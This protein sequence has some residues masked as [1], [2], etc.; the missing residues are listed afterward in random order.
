MIS[1]AFLVTVVILSLSGV[2]T[3]GPLFLA[4]ILRATKSGTMAGV[5]CAVGHTIVELPLVVGL[6]IG[7]SAFFSQPL[8]KAIAIV[9]GLVLVGLAVL[10][11]NQARS[12]IEMN[13]SNFSEKLSR[14]PTIL[15]GIA[16]TGLNPFF[17][18]W[19][20][21]VGTYLISQAYVA[22]TI[23][24]VLAMFAA[25]IW[26]DYAWLGGTASLASRGHLLLGR[27]YR[28]VLVVFGVVMMYFAASFIVSGLS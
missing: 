5:E 10:Q 7:L 19:W 6:A 16:L 14:R 18:L 2:L 22:G 26:M 9:G 24:D 21:T 20:L 25:H 8:L 1:P 4:S 17:L 27:W 13:P 28:G 3:P 11:L 12:K 15:A 23:I